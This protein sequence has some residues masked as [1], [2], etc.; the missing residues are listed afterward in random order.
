MN[1]AQAETAVTGS[2]LVVGGI[3]I[4]RRLSETDV[5]LTNAHGLR[6]K[7]LAGVGPVL[8]VGPFVVGWGFTFLVLALMAQARPDL[9]G[10]FAILV[11]AG[12]LLGNGES[13][14]QDVGNQLGGSSAKGG[15]GASR[16][17]TQPAP[18][19]PF[20]PHP[21]YPGRVV[22]SPGFTINPTSTH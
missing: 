17:D 2:A 9:G 21:S 4:Y 10:N 5:Q 18:P 3:Y 6:L 11:A 7:Q 16:P 20:E 13:V 12:A 8:P 15:A 22:I 1:Q 14:F 19:P